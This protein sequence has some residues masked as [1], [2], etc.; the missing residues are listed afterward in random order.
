M[1]ASAAAAMAVLP[2]PYSVFA[3]LSAF[4]AAISSALTAAEHLTYLPNP[5]V[6]VLLYFV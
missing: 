4:T 1:N 2:F 3:A 6:P 5:V